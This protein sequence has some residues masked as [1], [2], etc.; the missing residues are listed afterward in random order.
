[1]WTRESEQNILI[2]GHRGVRSLYPENTMVSFRA[3]LDMRLDL[4]E[5]D[6]HFTKDRQLV[7]CHDTTIDRTTNGTGNIRDMTLKELQSY[8]AGIKMG[9]QFA[10]AYIPTLTEVLELMA[11]ADYEVLLNV[12]I[13]DYDHDVVDATIAMLK[14]YGLDQRTVIA[15]FNAEVIAYT[16]K[17]HPEMRTQ[18]FPKRVMQKNTDVDF[19]ITEELYNNMFGIGIPLGEDV[20]VAREDVAFGFQIAG[21]ANNGV[22]ALELQK[23]NKYDLII[24]DLK[25][26]QMDGIEL[27]KRLSEEKETCKVIIVSAYGEFSYA[28]AAMRYGV[29]YYLLK[30]V[31]ENVLCGYLSKIAEELSGKEHV[32]E[33]QPDQVRFEHQ[34]NMSV[35]GVVT[36]IR[37]Y[38]N[39]HYNECLT[40]GSLS[41]IYN[42]SP[43]YLGRLF[44]KETGVSFNEYLNHCR[45]NAAKE[46]I[47]RSGYMMYE[48]AEQVGYKDINYFYKCFKDATGLTPKEYKVQMK[49]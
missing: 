6:V 29:K 32:Q 21:T 26:P 34:Y 15:C 37:R 27:I 43:V 17:A 5:F 49:K 36:E 20:E 1:M 39:K 11:N 3:A 23:Q 41:K 14:Q 48:I 46:Y 18:G 24:T 45:I 30:P 7:V 19:E 25:M 8:D 9:E 28:Q 44:K 35:N 31:D 4:I 2:V 40:L 38:V 16:Q 13:K 33:E 22:Q 12:E 47:C 42:F 10:G